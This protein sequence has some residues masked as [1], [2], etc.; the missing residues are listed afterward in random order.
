MLLKSIAEILVSCLGFSYDKPCRYLI[1]EEGKLTRCAL[2]YSVPICKGIWCEPITE[3]LMITACDKLADVA[4][5]LPN[6]ISSGVTDLDLFLCGGF[7]YAEHVAVIGEP[8]TMTYLA[9]NIVF[10][11]NKRNIKAYYYTTSDGKRL[12]TIRKMVKDI[13]GTM[14]MVDDIVNFYVKIREGYQL[15]D[16]LKEMLEKAQKEG[17]E[18]LLIIRDSILK[19][20]K[21]EALIP[22]KILEWEK[23]LGTINLRS[24]LLISM[25][26]SEMLD[27][28]T[29][30]FITD[31]FSL[32]IETRDTPPSLRVLKKE[33]GRASEWVG[34][35]LT[36]P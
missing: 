4:R 24:L 5:T 25:F 23:N 11:A 19:Y 2:D 16:M 10:T 36:V 12:S 35:E 26:E 21:E 9:M 1:S 3:E 28:E 6:K 7:Q 27:K 34:V 18:G 20:M 8:R 15:L 14:C 33:Q 22:K 31:T 17:Y 29:R 30:D 13:G 32:V